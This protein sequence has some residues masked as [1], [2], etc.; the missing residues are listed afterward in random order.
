MP[1]VN[2][3]FNLPEEQ[4]EFQDAVKASDYYLALWD[5]S[6]EVFRPARKHGYSDSEIQKLL[7]E[8]PEGK[9]EELISKLEDMFWEIMKERN[10][11]L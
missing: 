11:E 4:R 9:G 1:E 10:I 2:L 7:Q 6:Q 8:I 5:V 3:K